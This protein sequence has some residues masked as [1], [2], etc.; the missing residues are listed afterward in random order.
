MSATDSAPRRATVIVTPRE[1]FG[2][3]KQSLESLLA[4]R[5]EPF[6]IVYVD[7]GAPRALSDWIA[8]KAEEHDFVHLRR[9]EMMTPNG[10]RNLGVAAAKTPLVVFAD[11][12]VI[13]SDG[14]LTALCDCA[15]E[16]GAD[17]VAPMTCEGPELHAVIHQAG[18]QYAENEKGFFDTPRGQRRIV[19]L[20]PHQGERL[21]A[22]P[23]FERGEIGTC[24]FHCVLARRDLFGPD[25]IGPL[26]E[27]MLATK[28]HLDFCMSVHEIGGK[29]LIEPT[30]RV[31]YMFPNR[32]HALTAA[33][34]PF[35][36]V[37]WSAEW[38]T[39]S[40]DHFAQKWGLAPDEYFDK[41][42]T[43]VHWRRQHG[44]TKTMARMV[45]VLGRNQTFTQ[46]FV[47]AFDPLVRRY[48]SHLVS[49][50]DA[51]RRKTASPR[52]SSRFVGEPVNEAA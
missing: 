19:D 32:H 23:P 17:V 22:L 18:G 37:R 34:F 21:D 9:K 10:A 6:D 35:F 40:L 47:S 15:E 13:F 20:M 42:Y 28:E 43:K 33:D 52:P 27:D 49:R 2:I 26:D 7:A 11:N 38:Q 8:R 14:W 29:V 5:D 44:V 31:T 30:S 24:E 36:L 3:A 25:R 51:Q 45:P 1:R 12:D 4:C 50:Q 16:E 41:R 39:R 46:W 48:A